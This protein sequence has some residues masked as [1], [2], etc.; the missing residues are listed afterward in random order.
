MQNFDKH[1]EISSKIGSPYR[2]DIEYRHR[3]QEQDKKI[4]SIRCI[5]TKFCCKSGQGTISSGGVIRY[6]FIY[7]FFEILH[8]CRVE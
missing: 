6:I 8:V 3:M 5:N 1:M 7:N 2:S 4:E